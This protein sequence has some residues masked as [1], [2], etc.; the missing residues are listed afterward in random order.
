MGRECL[1]DFQQKIILAK[2]HR[3]VLYEGLGEENCPENG[4]DA[5]LYTSELC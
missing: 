3:V 4:N 1:G 2:T 5:A